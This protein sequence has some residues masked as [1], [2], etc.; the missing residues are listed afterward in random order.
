MRSAQLQKLKTRL[1]EVRSQPL[2]FGSN[3]SLTSCITFAPQC[4][5]S[6][7]FSRSRASGT[8]LVYPLPRFYD[9]SHTREYVRL[10]YRKFTRS[11]GPQIHTYTEH[12]NARV[13]SLI[14]RTEFVTMFCA[15]H[16]LA[17]W[18]RLSSFY[19]LAVVRPHLDLYI[20][21]RKAQAVKIQHY[22]AMRF[23]GHRL[24]ITLL[25][26]LKMTPHFFISTGLLVRYF[27]GRK[28]LRKNRSMK[29]LLARFMRKIL[30]VLGLA[31]VRV[32]ARGVPLFL[33]VFL[34]MLFRPL[35]HPFSDPMTGS[36]IDETQN[37]PLNIGISG[38]D[39]H[40]PKPFGYQ[41]QKK[42]GRIKR[43][44]RRKLTRLN[45]IID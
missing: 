16:W 1:K 32:L 10:K 40:Q 41:K 21:I 11:F 28:S 3:R 23:N 29:L 5:P 30:I 19:S 36:K 45:R 25:D 43:K 33:E 20:R 2:T 37:E 31:D 8:E 17:P 6:K 34:A 12:L 26:K 38:V 42:K 27:K 18:Y 24:I 14:A 7:S 22:L 44:I 13:H 9:F 35:G 4:G 15:A 39:F